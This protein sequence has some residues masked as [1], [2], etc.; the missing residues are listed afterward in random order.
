MNEDDFLSKPFKLGT[1]YILFTIPNQ[2]VLGPNWLG[3]LIFAHG[4]FP[5]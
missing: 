4:L 2:L 3:E 5:F 1:N